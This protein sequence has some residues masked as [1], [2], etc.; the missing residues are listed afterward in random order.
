MAGCL[1]SFGGR[2]KVDFAFAGSSRILG[3]TISNGVK[4]S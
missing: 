1:P 2:E 4:V 3:T